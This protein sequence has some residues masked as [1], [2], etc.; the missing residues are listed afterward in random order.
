VDNSGDQISGTQE[1]GLSRKV[2]KANVAA[3]L[4]E[5]EADKDAKDEAAVLTER[6]L[7]VSQLWNFSIVL[8]DV[9]LRKGN[10]SL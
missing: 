3:R 7:P 4:K 1:L 8:H 6:S 5:I 10:T 2:N 9:M